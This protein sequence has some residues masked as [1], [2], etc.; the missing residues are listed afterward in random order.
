M[1]YATP[2]KTND[3][4]SEVT[5][6]AGDLQV[7]INTVRGLVFLRRRCHNTGKYKQFG[8]KELSLFD[9]EGAAIAF[10]KD[11]MTA[12]TGLTRDEIEQS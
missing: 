11:Y 10:V 9:S 8:T 3:W 5:L 4:E 1:N 12:V 7:E 2:N 6:T